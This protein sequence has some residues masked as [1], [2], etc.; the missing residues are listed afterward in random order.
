MKKVILFLFVFVS[1]F[2]S[3][4]KDAVEDSGTG[5]DGSIL[6][7]ALSEA[8]SLPQKI[9]EASMYKITK[10]KLKGKLNSTDVWFLREMAG[11]FSKGILSYLDLSEAEFVTGGKPYLGD[12]ITEPNKVS[13]AMFYDCKALT[14]VKIPQNTVTID[15]D[16]F[17]DCPGLLSFDIPNS[18]KN[19]ESGAFMDCSNLTSIIIPNS[20]LYIGDRAF[21][22]TKIHELTIPTSVEICSL[23][24]MD[25][26]EV[27]RI[28]DSDKPMDLSLHS[29]NL[30]YLY[31]G[32]NISADNFSYLKYLDS[33]KEIEIGEKVTE[34]CANYGEYGRLA[35]GTINIHN[36]IKT[37]GENAFYNTYLS[38]VVLPPSVE[39]I[40]RR[41]L[42]VC[43]ENLTLY[44]KNPPQVAEDCFYKPSECTLYVPKGCIDNYKNNEKWKGFKEYKEIDNYLWEPR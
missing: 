31:L 39:R 34:V 36:G 38:N 3:C 35:I 4:S 25:N 12:R 43:L 11:Y 2:T 22:R 26:L 27:L 30:E 29:L 6:T 5:I 13:E 19:I 1:L 32:R 44:T 16:A 23:S 9:D 40:G 37:I 8:G 10:L 42:F 18:V 28:E 20:I 24:G 21:Y 17:K 14:E 15:R 41:G 33:I 7:L